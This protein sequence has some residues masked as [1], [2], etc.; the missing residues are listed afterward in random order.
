MPQPTVC[1]AQPVPSRGG[2]V[3]KGMPLPT[4]LALAAAQ[5]ARG[6]SNRQVARGAGVDPSMVTHYRK[7]DS[8]PSLG[9]VERWASAIGARLAVV[10]EREGLA[11]DLGTVAE[12]L[13]ME[14][15]ALVLAAA[16]A[17]LAAR[18]DPMKRVVC[19]AGLRMAA[20]QVDQLPAAARRA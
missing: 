13:T 19:V 7:G 1:L 12:D 16:R 2:R 14:D 15:A 11:A 8:T 20:E 5:D 4:V 6:V 18:A 10:T 17:L 9:V 3:E